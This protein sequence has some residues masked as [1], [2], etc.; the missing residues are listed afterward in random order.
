M[1]R[2][3]FRSEPAPWQGFGDSSDNRSSGLDEKVHP[4]VQL[5]EDLKEEIL[6]AANSTSLY[7]DYKQKGRKIT[8]DEES[9][10]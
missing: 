3:R 10:L 4:A 2:L 9:W 7:C 5:F 8:D 6:E 1:G